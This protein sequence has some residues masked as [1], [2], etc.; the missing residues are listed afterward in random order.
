VQTRA[1]VSTTEVAE[2]T[3]V[4]RVR[5]DS[6]STIR[7]SGTVGGAGGVHELKHPPFRLPSS[8]GDA[9]IRLRALCDL[10]G[11]NFWVVQFQ[12]RSVIQTEW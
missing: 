2:N 5:T 9:G 6:A 7:L 3:E 1:E 12:V 8:S 4:E 10:C 11:E